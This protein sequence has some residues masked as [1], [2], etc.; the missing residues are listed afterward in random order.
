MRLQRG[1]HLFKHALIHLSLRSSLR[2]EMSW[3][4]KLLSAWD[5][6]STTSHA[7]GVW[8]YTEVVRRRIS[9]ESPCSCDT[10]QLISKYHHSRLRPCRDNV[11]QVPA[12]ENQPQKLQHHHRRPCP[13]RS[14]RLCLNE[15]LRI[16]K[17]H[18]HHG[19]D[20]PEGQVRQ[21][22]FSGAAEKLD[23]LAVGAGD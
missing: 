2:L 18:G 10:V 22:V 4:S 23:G 13:N 7:Q 9:Y 11:V 19:R 12:T 6:R 8:L 14:M 15:S 3:H 1:S 20:E 17:Q 21:H 5:R 16:S